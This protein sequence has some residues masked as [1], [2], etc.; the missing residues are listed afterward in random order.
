[1]ENKDYLER[2]YKTNFDCALKYCQQK[3]WSEAKRSLEK[4][5]EA[6]LKL[7][8]LTYGA[9]QERLMAKVKSLRELLQ[10]VKTRAVAPCATEKANASKTSASKEN[11]QKEN[12]P[13][14]KISVE[15]ALN[16]LNELVGLTEVKREVSDLIAELEI[17]AERKRLGLVA[18]TTNHHMVFAGSPGTG[19]TT[20]ARIMADILYSIG[21]IEKGQLVEVG[22]ADLVAGYVGQT[23]AKTRE[24]IN[25]AMGGVLFIDEIY[26]LA[27]GG[28]NDFGKE[29][30]GEIL[31][32]VENSRGEF[33]TILAGYDTR[34][35]EFFEMNEG[36]KDRFPTKLTFADYDADE[37][38]EIFKGMCK[39]GQFEISSEASG[40]IKATLNKMY[41]ERDP[42]SFGN[43]RAVRN[44]Y[45]KVQRKQK[46]R[47]HNERNDGKKL[48]AEDLMMFLPQDIPEI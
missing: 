16:K 15:E 25:E 4:A 10:D 48:T 22:K 36:L 38:Y 21:I 47:L 12:T 31:T 18:A 45:E 30:V 27:E 40:K 29:A 33:V 32:A 26:R 41:E 24:K 7:V 14:E 20:V 3:N 5:G 37:M 42:V 2:T 43:A 28:Q 34:M 1:M 11:T 46:V 8:P 13:K 17:D 9:E 19:K 44:L 6:L 23:G 39:K 35:H